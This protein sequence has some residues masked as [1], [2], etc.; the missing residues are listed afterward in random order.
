MTSTYLVHQALLR[1]FKGL[2]AHAV[3]AVVFLIC[4][5]GI[6][7]GRNLRWNTWDVLVHPTGLLF[8]VSDRLINPGAYPQAFIVTSTFFIIIGSFYTVAYQ[9]VRAL[10]RP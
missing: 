7:L 6:Y 8:D 3:V 5:F 4:S 1:C 10:Q 2:Q 9:A